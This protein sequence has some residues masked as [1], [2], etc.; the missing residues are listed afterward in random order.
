MGDTFV[1]SKF[2]VSWQPV[3][4]YILEL[5]ELRDF[6]TYY[7]NNEKG[8]GSEIVCIFFRRIDV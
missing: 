7:N 4:E 2:L 6:Q 3:M 1:L 8:R 5:V